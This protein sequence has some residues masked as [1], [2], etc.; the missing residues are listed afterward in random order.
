M[1]QERVGDKPTPS[2]S[3]VELKAELKTAGRKERKEVKRKK[4]DERVGD[5]TALYIHCA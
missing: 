5:K 3:N 4:V 1:D 2:V